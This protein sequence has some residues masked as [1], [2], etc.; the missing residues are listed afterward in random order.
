[1]VRLSVIAGVI[2]GVATV[3]DMP[4]A[5]TTET[6]VT[7]PDPEAAVLPFSFCIACRILS[8]AATVPAP[9]T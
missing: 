1:V 9:D 5:V 8:V 2:V 4:L 6:E 3:P 7:V